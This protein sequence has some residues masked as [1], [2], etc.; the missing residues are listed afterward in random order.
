MYVLGER[1]GENELYFPQ[2][3]ALCPA[4]LHLLHTCA[5]FAGGW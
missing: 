3:R 2:V 4:V 1:E 5:R